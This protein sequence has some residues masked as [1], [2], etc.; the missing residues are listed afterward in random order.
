MVSLHGLFEKFF[1]I[2]S[3]FRLVTFHEVFAVTE[4]V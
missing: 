2:K 4:S 1:W 3:G